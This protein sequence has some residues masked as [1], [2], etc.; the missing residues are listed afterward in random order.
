ML[1]LRISTKD[2]EDNDRGI[3]Y[4]L[5]FKLADESEVIKVGVTKR[6]IEDRVVEILTG[7]F[8]HLRYFPYCKPKKFTTVDKVYEKEAEMHRRLAEF[9]HKFDY[10]FGGSTEYFSGVS[11]EAII[12]EY[13][14]VCNNYKV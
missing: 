9:S 6:K 4:V 10:V 12:K 14:D 1:K 2:I 13:E 8:K 5:V 3:L 11:V 7:M